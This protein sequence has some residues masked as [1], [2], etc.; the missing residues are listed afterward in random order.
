MREVVFLRQ[1]VEKW[2]GYETLLSRVSTAKADDLADMYTTLMDDLAY[3]KTY[4]PQSTTTQYLNSLAGKVHQLI[5]RNKSEERKRLFTFWINDVPRMMYERRHQLWLA[6]VIFMLSVGIGVISAARDE[7]FVRL[8]LGDD[9]VNMTLENIRRGD[10]M[11]VYK[12]A[13][14][15]EMFINIALNNIMVGLRAFAA[16]ILVSVGTVLMMFYNGVM[17]GSFQYF[18]A[19][20]NLLWE[21]ALVIWI[22][23][24]L[25]ISVIVVCG[26]AGLVM[27]NSI[28]FPGTYTRLQSFQRGAKDGLKIVIGTIPIFIV[29]AFLEGFVTRYTGMPLWLSILIIGSSAVFI[30]WYFVVYPIR[31]FAPPRVKRLLRTVQ[32]LP[33]SNLV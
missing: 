14:P 19:T 30:L 2:Q 26:A 8:V 3:A 33:P 31:R 28:L 25:E 21:S 32:A 29:A 13:D 11:A 23:G 16:G 27:G 7:V 10:P 6:F 20:K 12:S 22:H 1:N 4:Y 18:F 5:H 17:L 15:L 24:T 9:Y